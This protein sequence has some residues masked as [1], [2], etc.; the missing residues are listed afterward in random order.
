MPDPIPTQDR[1]E[2]PIA[3]FKAMQE[4]WQLIADLQGGTRS[5]RAR[6]STYLPRW[7]AE[8]DE[9]Y[10][11][12]VARSV[13]YEAFSDTVKK[14]AA[15]PFS[16]PVTVKNAEKLHPRLREF[17][18]DVDGLG[19]DITTFSRMLFIDALAFGKTHVFTDLAGSS[20]SLTH[21]E[22]QQLGIR[23]YWN[24]VKAREL[25]GWRERQLPG[26]AIE[27]EQAR[28][29]EAKEEATGRFGSK[30]VRYVRV[31]N[32]DGTWE[33][34]REPESGKEWSTFDSGT[35]TFKG[36]PLR[37]LNLM[38]PGRWG[39][40]PPLESLAWLNLAHF[41]SDSDQRS[42][43]HYARAFLIFVSGVTTEEQEKPIAF[44]PGAVFRSTNESAR[45]D[46]V[47]HGGAAIT[48]GER[49]LKELETRMEVLGLAPLLDTRTG[50]ATGQMLDASQSHAGI[51][52]W[53]RT[54][55]RFL[56]DLL[57]D[58]GQWIGQPVP[59]DVSVDIFSEF[60][61]TL[62]GASD[63]GVVGSAR[64]AGDLS[65]R[66]YLSELKRR[67]ILSDDV[68][69]EDEMELLLEESAA[70]L[71]KARA[72][73][74]PAPGAGA[75]DDQAADDGDGEDPEDDQDAD[76]GQDPAEKK[77]PPMMAGA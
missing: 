32:I 22:Q 3:A 56:T 34:Y 47:E 24:H 39:A 58:A 69:I 36:M 29:L 63:M 20:I 25:I 67:G 45:M 12:R 7:D 50:T 57:R 10:A 26:G 53:I 31:L 37:V 61:S 72:F 23:P 19:N 15:K 60:A 46:V 59:D 21:A 76:D 51:Q 1:V 62:A 13:L 2:E 73:G 66:T 16:R 54:G 74:L 11:Q 68:D 70:A 41:C 35:F 6:S 38:D 17:L 52:A 27:I 77:R 55:E 75:G 49:D 14:L 33:L 64:Q 44:G 65:L 18:K 30:T 42:I 43:L 9:S 28:I 40:T 48:S 71:E 4:A 5:M 8:K